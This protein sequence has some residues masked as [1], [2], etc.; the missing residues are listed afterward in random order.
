MAE[1]KTEVANTKE[2][3]QARLVVN[4]AFV[5]APP[6]TLSMIRTMKH[7]IV[8]PKIT[9]EL[10]ESCNLLSLIFIIFLLNIWNIRKK[11]YHIHIS[12]SRKTTESMALFI[13][14]IFCNEL[15]F[16]IYK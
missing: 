14:I 15:F 5:D 2:K 4:N 3:E 13:R 1:K 8:K 10:N 6:V 12:I 9:G 16:F 11:L 7:A